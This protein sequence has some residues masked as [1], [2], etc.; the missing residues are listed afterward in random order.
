M[1]K[2]TKEAEAAFSISRVPYVPDQFWLPPTSTSS[3]WCTLTRQRPGRCHGND[4]ALSHRDALYTSI[5]PPGTSE[6]RRVIEG[7]YA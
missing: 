7:R 5:L 2:W 1:V 6:Q 4:D 3:L